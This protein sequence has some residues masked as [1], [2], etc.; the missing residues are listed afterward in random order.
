[1]KKYI[2]CLLLIIFMVP[3]FLCGQEDTTNG[4]FFEDLLLNEI[5]GDVKYNEVLKYSGN[6]IVIIT[7]D[8]IQK[9]GFTSFNDIIHYVSD[10]SIG[11]DMLW[12]FLGVRGVTFPNSYGSRVAITIDGNFLTDYTFASILNSSVLEISLDFIE[13]VEI[14]SGPPSFN[15]GYKGILGAINIVTKDGKDFDG[16]TVKV[17]TTHTGETHFELTTGYKLENGLDIMFSYRGTYNNGNN[18]YFEE[19]DNNTIYGQKYTVNAAGDSILNPYYNP[20]ASN[21][22]IADHKDN[23]FGN[24]FYLHANFNNFSLNVMQTL[25]NRRYPSAGYETIFNDNDA[26]IDMSFTNII[27]KYDYKADLLGMAHNIKPKI[28]YTRSE[29]NLYYNFLFEDED[30]NDETILWNQLENPI[31]SGLMFELLDNIEINNRSNLVAAVSYTSTLDYDIRFAEGENKAFDIETKDIL[32]YIKIFSGYFE[33]T[34]DL[35]DWFNFFVGLRYEHSFNENYTDEH[36]YSALLPRVGVIFDVGKNSIIKAL[37]GTAART[38]SGYENYYATTI[39]VDEITGDS[40]YKMGHLNYENSRL[41]E[42]NYTYLSEDFSG[43]V[44]I[45][46]NTIN[47]FI[48]ET[49]IDPDVIMTI[50]ETYPYLTTNADNVRINTFGVSI[51][52]KYKTNFGI[53]LFI[54]NTYSYVDIDN[55]SDQNL[56]EDVKIGSYKSILIYGVSIE[57]IDFL[58]LNLLGKYETGRIA[59]DKT[60]DEE[61]G[62]TTLPSAHKLNMDLVYRPFYQQSNLK[63]LNK[64]YAV[65]SLKNILNRKDY[66][67]VAYTFG[68]ISKVPRDNGYSIGLTLGYKF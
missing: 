28:Q 8:D 32:C 44:S 57:L 47:N 52:A 35:T 23:S 68:T 58:Y 55:N 20:R 15:Y 10:Y 21:G 7:A 60:I 3:A 30:E 59:I 13:R 33:Y 42:V 22:G 46:H 25:S 41:Y 34:N 27:L 1:M 61:Y 56:I 43:K 45:F 54:G 62:L 38:P 14:I 26:K 9:K 63:F 53:D 31:F 17:G 36:I 11:S 66:Y 16:G 49:K 5:S 29:S 19:Y 18:I 24:V 50:D 12:N 65:L 39:E 67:P 6:S 40:T 48:Y 51:F 64:F 4:H 2:T 37:F